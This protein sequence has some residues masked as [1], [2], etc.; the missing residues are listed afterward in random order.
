MEQLVIWLVTCIA[1]SFLSIS[2]PGLGLVLVLGVRIF[3]PSLGGSLLI[4]D[5]EGN[6]AIHPGTI[7]L[8]VLFVALF[9]SR[10]VQMA[11]ELASM[12]VVYASLIL[13]SGAFVVITL[14]QRGPSPLLGM[15]NAFIAPMIFF[16]VAR[17]E[18][19]SSDQAA[20]RLTTAFLAFSA[21]Q[22]LLVFA[23][24]LLGQNLPWTGPYA[25]VFLQRPLGTFDSP[26]DLGLAMVLAIPLLWRVRNPLTRYGA[27]L[28]FFFAA[29]LSASRTP[30]LL[31]AV[32]LVWLLFTSARH[33][34]EVVVAIAITAFG[35]SALLTTAIIG[36]LMT[37][38]TVDD[39][40]SGSARSYAFNYI[41]EHLRD[42]IF[43]GGGWGS[44]YRL[45]GSVLATSLESGYAIYAFD[46]GVVLTCALVAIQFSIICRRTQPII[47]GARLSAL[48]G[49][50]MAFVYSGITT[51]SASS[52]LLWAVLSMCALSQDHVGDLGVATRDQRLGQNRRAPDRMR[53]PGSQSPQVWSHG[54]HRVE[55]QQARKPPSGHLK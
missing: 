26:L 28:L 22:A 11:A 15:T 21:I 25:S 43:I 4:G 40:N 42:F 36:G 48:L 31:A 44:S 8:I 27:G 29:V 6:A 39:G 55:Q 16:F 24:W 12:P 45:K 53:S 47:R 41:V 20:R 30:T 35:C 54:L 18:F 5:W 50:G 7:L 32:A 13:L 34:R 33:F 3:V 46:L 14:F 1:L 2:R 37:R 23:Q 9:S 17:V 52:L 19:R 10:S 49:I 51:M 38:L